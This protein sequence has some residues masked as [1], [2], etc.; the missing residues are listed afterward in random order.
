M[1]RNLLLGHMNHETGE[2]TYGV[3]TKCAREVEKQPL[4]VKCWIIC[5]GDV[6]PEWIEAL[7]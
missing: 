7:N 5:D 4:D 3:L 6:D 2:Y 1:P